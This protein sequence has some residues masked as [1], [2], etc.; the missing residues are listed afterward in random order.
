MQSDSQPIRTLHEVGPKQMDAYVKDLQSN[1]DL[2]SIFDVYLNN[3][4][5]F[6]VA[7]CNEEIIGMGGLKKV[8]RNTAETKRLRVTR[9]HQGKGMGKTVLGELIRKAKELGYKKL[10]VDTTTKQILT[11]R[12]FEKV[13]FREIRRERLGR[14]EQVFYEM[15]IS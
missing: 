7:I 14:L 3:E 6:L 2:D 11:Q 9:T 1:R 8:D 5:E 4:G 13:G 12:L 15:T 10:I